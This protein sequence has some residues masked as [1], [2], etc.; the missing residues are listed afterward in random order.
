MVRE[1][2][3]LEQER[4]TRMLRSM[5]TLIS[6]RRREIIRLGR[7]THLLAAVPGSIMEQGTTI[8]TLDLQ[9]DPVIYP[10]FKMC[11]SVHLLDV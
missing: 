10:E 2:V 6:E 9:Q 5:I 11:S 3:F 8:H 4:D 7:K 1:I